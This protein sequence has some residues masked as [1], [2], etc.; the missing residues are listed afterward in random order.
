MPSQHLAAKLSALLIGCA[1][2]P[3]SSFA[4]LTFQPSQKPIPAGYTVVAHGDFNND[5]IEDLV[6]VDEYINNGPEYL[7]LSNGG[8]TYRAPIMLPNSIR[9]LGVQAIGDFNRDGKL[10]IA[11]VVSGSTDLTV[12]LGKGDGTFQAPRSTPG[13]VYVPNSLL[14]VDLN[15]DGKTDLVEFILSYTNGTIIPARLQLLIS[16][17][18]GTF[19]K[20]QTIVAAT[21]SLANQ[22]AQ[23]ALTGDFDGDG[24]PDIALLYGYI[25]PS[26]TQPTTVQVFYGDGAGHLGSPSLTTDSN[27][28]SDS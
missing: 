8:G 25:Q 7:F 16:N 23:Y 20:G 21:G 1:L 5:G 18:D 12:Y 13:T 19:S 4:Q 11:T 9:G 15:H 22:V 2:L 6:A 17:G 24:K 10:D 3:L 14:A 26:Q 27:G 28:Y